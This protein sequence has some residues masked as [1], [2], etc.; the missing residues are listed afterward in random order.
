[1]F[2][3]KYAFIISAV[4]VLLCL[5]L[6][7]RIK[8]D[9]SYLFNKRIVYIK[10]VADKEFTSYS[11]WRN[12]IRTIV[13]QGSYQFR[14]QLGI[15]LKVR[16]IKG[17]EVES[18]F[19]GIN[20]QIKQLKSRLHWVSLAAPITYAAIDALERTKLKMEI[21]LLAEH[22]AF[23]GCDIIV[24]FSG[25]DYIVNNGLAESLIGRRALV[26][27]GSKKIDVEKM[28]NLF[29][30]EIGHLFGAVHFYQES[31]V[32]W[33]GL[34]RSSKFDKVNKKIILKNKWRDFKRQPEK[35]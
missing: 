33:P 34:R 9:R 14:T 17:L 11:D 18:D 20:K 6:Y 21:G 5:V 10:A 12:L 32:M 8:P 27:S 35:N 23:E 24:Y 3:T 29:V 1:V 15:E 30:H 28:V 16:I 13:K 26:S 22:V 7:P 25:K 2:K 4:L 19:T 31:S